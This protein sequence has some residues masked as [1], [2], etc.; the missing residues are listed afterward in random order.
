MTITALP[1][2]AV[3]P[4]P[5]IGE[6]VKLKDATI[7]PSTTTASQPVVVTTSL[8]GNIE[9]DLLALDVA[10]RARAQFETRRD[11]HGFANRDLR[12]TSE[13]FAKFTITSLDMVEVHAVG[14]R[15]F[16]KALGVST[17]RD[18]AFVAPAERAD[19]HKYPAFE[20][21]ATVAIR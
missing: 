20:A 16:V 4:M 2:L 3:G 1:P 19:W 7:S 8:D 14:V 9:R 11:N 21:G 12:F 18:R 5:S 10:S 13:D 6:S 15:T 17:R